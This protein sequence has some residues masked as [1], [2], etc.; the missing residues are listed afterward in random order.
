V[1][2]PNRKPE[3]ELEPEPGTGT[4]TRNSE[5]RT[6]TRNRNPNPELGTPNPNPE[7]RTPN[8]EPNPLS[9]IIVSVI[10]HVLN[11]DALRSKLEQSSVQGTLAVWADALHDGPVPQ[12]LSDDELARLRARHF[13]GLMGEPEDRVVEMALGWNA[14][15]A[16]YGEFDEVVFWFEHDL[17]DQLILLRHLHW[18]STIDAGTTRFSLICIGSFPG[19]ANFTGLGPLSPEQLAT[20]PGVR[21]PITPVHIALGREAWPLFRAPDPMPLLGWMSGDLSPLP[22]LHGALLRH[23]EDYPATG[24]GL[25]RSERQILRAVRQGEDTFGGIFVACQR[26]EERIFMGDVTFA[27]IL[28]RLAGGR[29]PLLTLHE[30]LGDPRSPAVR[31]TLNDLG[32]VVL[33]GGADYVELNGIDRWMGGVHLSP[34]NLWRWDSAAGILTP[35][36]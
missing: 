10:L 3:P 7:P 2:S 5:P 4:G 26:M 28:E 6:R 15:L 18:L 12:G 8:P 33:D 32:E 36:D 24:D 9:T 27:P 22:F 35:D 31:V 14:A 19:V 29:N 1:G 34:G 16:R 21:R 11:G 20:L 13:A 17:F 25:S 23:F 30:A